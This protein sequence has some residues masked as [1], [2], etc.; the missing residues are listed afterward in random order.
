MAR[1]PVQDPA[2]ARPASIPADWEESVIPAQITRADIYGS[3]GGSRLQLLV[4]YGSPR[5]SKGE[6]IMQADEI[7]LLAEFSAAKPCGIVGRQIST[8]HKHPRGRA[9][10][11]VLLEIEPIL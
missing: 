7:G 10:G 8:Y 9:D 2:E 4:R 5:S 11:G 1:Y 3:D 6:I